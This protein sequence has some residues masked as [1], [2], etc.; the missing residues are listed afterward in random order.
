[1]AGSPALTAVFNDDLVKANRIYTQALNPKTPDKIYSWHAPEVECIA[2]GKAHKKYEFGCKVSVAATNAG[3][4]IV[5]AM[6][7]HG[8]PYDGHTLSNVLNQIERLTGT[9]PRE[10]YVD[11]GY[12]GHDVEARD[13]EIILAR[14][15]RGITP[16]KRKRQR[17]AMPSNPSSATARTTAKSAPAIGFRANGA[18]RSTPWPWPSVS[19]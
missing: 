16:V 5:G 15:K 18:T 17:R 6:A 7:H 3:N 8:R 1:M 9:K 14:Q 4:F 10:A 12:R 13:T 19:M 2:K 11:L